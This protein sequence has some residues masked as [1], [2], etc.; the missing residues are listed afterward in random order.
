MGPFGKDF[1]IYGDG[2]NRGGQAI[3]QQLGLT[4]PETVRKDL[5]D[6]K[7]NALNIS[8]EKIADYAGDYIFWIY[9]VAQNLMRIH[10]YGQHWMP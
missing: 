1:Y 7:I 8:Q 5:I 4:P 2:V 6:S 9:L 3:Y 10:R